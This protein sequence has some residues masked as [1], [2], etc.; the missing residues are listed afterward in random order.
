M[1]LVTKFGLIVSLILSGVVFGQQRGPRLLVVEPSFEMGFMPDSSIVSHTYW[2]NNIGTDSLRIFRVKLT[3]GCTKAPI[4]EG[5]IAVNDSLPLEIIFD[6]NKREKK[7]TRTATIY[8]NDPAASQ[9]EVSFRTYIY[10]TDESTGPIAVLKNRR[11]R[12]SST[13]KGKSVSVVLKNVSKEPLTAR[14]VVSPED[15]VSIDLPQEPIAPGAKA[16]VV[17][18]LKTGLKEKYYNKSFTIEMSD[19]A[20]SRY[21]FPIHVAE[22]QPALK[23]SEKKS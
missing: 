18:H 16:D 9:Y 5:V 10:T 13:D 7:Q 4:S 3:C 21:T 15:L 8:C 19:A 20:K 12:L 23:A 6:N 17:I 2:V 1:R 22:S 14:L 11:V